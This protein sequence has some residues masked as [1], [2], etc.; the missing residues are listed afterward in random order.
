MTPTARRLLAWGAVLTSAVALSITCGRDV[1]PLPE[2]LRRFEDE[3][4]QEA[5]CATCH[6][7][8][9]PAEDVPVISTELPT[10]H[11][12]TEP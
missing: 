4:V 12:A 5:G 3:P 7:P 9:G 11:P 2:D 1:P 6:A 10:D 8:G